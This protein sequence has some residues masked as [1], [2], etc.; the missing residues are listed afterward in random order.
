MGSSDFKAFD[1]LTKD[2]LKTNPYDELYWHE[3]LQI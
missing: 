1:N 3:H 2:Y